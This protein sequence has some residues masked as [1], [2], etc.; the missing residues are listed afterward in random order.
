M[1]RCRPAVLLLLS[2]L[3]LVQWVSHATAKRIALV[4]GNASYQHLPALRNTTNDA[5]AIARSLEYANF[6]VTKLINADLISMKRAFLAFGRAMREDVDATFIF[7]AGHG[8]QVSGENYLMPV[9]ANVSYEDEVAIEGI[10]ANDFLRVLNGSRGAVNIVV[11]DACRNNPFPTSLRGA[12]AGLAPVLAPRGT[13]IAYSTAPGSV[14]WDGGG[15][16]S[17]FTAALA[18]TMRLPGL[19]IAQVFRKV[20]GRVLE[21]TEGKQ[22][23]WESSSII[24]EFFFISQAAKAISP[25]EVEVSPYLAAATRWK[26]LE[27]GTDTAALEAFAKQYE[28]NLFGA[29]ARARLS[30]IA[31]QQER[32]SSAADGLKTALPLPTLSPELHL[33]APEMNLAALPPPGLAETAQAS[34]PSDPARVKQALDAAKT[35]NT[36][37]GWQLFLSRYGQEKDAGDAAFEALR[38]LATAAGAAPSAAE[39]ERALHLSAGAISEVQT[40][41]AALGYGVGKID[42]AFGNRTRSGIASYQ[43]HLGL[44]ATGFVDLNVLH[45]LGIE[46][47]NIIV[48]DFKSDRRAKV[49]NADMLELLGED[50]RVVEMIRCLPGRSIVY[51]RFRGHVYAAANYGSRN[52]PTFDAM[53]SK[54]NSHLVSISDHAEN[55][56]VYDLVAE[57]PTFWTF[58]R[59]REHYNKHGPM[60][61]LV[62]R[63]DSKEPSGGWQWADGDRSSFRRWDR[64][65]PD[66]FD[67]IEHHS[68]FWGSALSATSLKNSRADRWNDLPYH[69]GRFIIEHDSAR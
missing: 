30:Q 56:F 50:A 25:V 26:E 19:E 3:C 13:L 17:D 33:D 60:L 29:A 64:G 52:L 68:E 34:R 28:D 15:E 44:R 49:Y 11:L 66:N 65:Q 23:P 62:Q 14:A 42:G 21:R 2:F 16:N 8:V 22:T 20:R 27:A 35:I 38:G 48:E 58:E 46:W 45:N 24:G 43:Q 57:E 54:C 59:Y 39:L 67:N 1:T 51:G 4:V 63:R 6:E 31:G 9:D 61:G 53:L 37:R 18:E 40:K 12:A 32:P 10:N 41:L 36:A 5:D 47:G 69:G 55:T 7:Y